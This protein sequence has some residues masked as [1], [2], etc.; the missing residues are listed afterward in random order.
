MIEKH[1]IGELEATT[2][3]NGLDVLRAIGHNMIPIHIQRPAGQYLAKRQSRC[4]IRR[5]N[6]ENTLWREMTHKVFNRVDRSIYVLN[7]VQ[8]DDKIELPA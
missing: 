8:K 3:A 2:V 7:H 4:S 5:R 1:N 6:A